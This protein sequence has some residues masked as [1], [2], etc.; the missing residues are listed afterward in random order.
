MTMTLW[1]RLS[2]ANVQKAVWALEEVGVE[3]R[4]IDK[5][6]KFGG[7]DEPAYRALNPNGLVPTL[8]DGNVTVWESHAIVRYLS[9]EYASGLLWPV[10][11]QDRAV[12]DQWTDWAA[13]TFQ[14]AW[15]GVYA[16][17]VRLPKDQQN[18]EVLAANLARA[19][20][21]YAI[22][23]RQLA[24][25]PYV[26]GENFTYADIVIGVSMYRWTTMGI[27]LLDRPHLDAWHKRLTA[28]P[29]YVKAVE[30][31]YEDQRGA[32]APR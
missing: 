4:Q 3:Y 9:A 22:L 26:A 24:K 2:S 18:P 28:R 30:V 13:T 21:L 12:V 11:P 16:Q 5:G 19:N 29:A 15:I 10:E 1:G 31:S 17:L 27:E 23:D 14:P 7:L 20:G 6:G 25:T 8:E 32:G